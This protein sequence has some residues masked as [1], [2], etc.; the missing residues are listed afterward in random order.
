MTKSI[1]A[2]YQLTHSSDQQDEI[3]VQ[4]L[5]A[6]SEK[7]EPPPFRLQCYMKVYLGHITNN[8]NTTNVLVITE[9]KPPTT[10]KLLAIDLIKR[11]DTDHPS[12]QL[13]VVRAPDDPSLPLHKIGMTYPVQLHECENNVEDCPC[14]GHAHCEPFGCFRIGGIACEYCNRRRH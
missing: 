12:K 10:G 13:M 9:E 1:C 14:C 5:K 6:L 4:R 11:T 3:E 2:F 7:F 8:L